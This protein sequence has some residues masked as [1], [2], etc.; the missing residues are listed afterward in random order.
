MYNTRTMRRFSPSMR[1]VA[2]GI[3]VTVIA[4]IIWFFNP[5]YLISRN[6]RCYDYFIQEHHLLEKSNVPVIVDIDE[7]SLEKYGQWPWPRYRLASMLNTIAESAPAAIGLDILFG[8]PDR[9]S[10][11]R[12]QSELQHELGFDVQFVGLPGYL[13]KHDQ[14]M[15]DALSNT[16]S[17]LGF[18]CRFDQPRPSEDDVLNSFE[19]GVGQYLK[20]RPFRILASWKQAGHRRD[21]ILAQGFVATGLITPIDILAQA[22]EGSGFM[23]AM[24]DFDGVLRRTPLLIEHETSLYPSLALALIQM[25][26]KESLMTLQMENRKIEVTFPADA[27]HGELNIPLDASANLFI[28]FRGAGKNYPY[29][30]A[31]DVLGKAVSPEEFKDKIVLVGS[32]AT[33]LKD[34]HVSPFGPDLVGVETHAAVIDTILTGDY[35]VIPS[36][37]HIIELAALLTIGLVIT[38]VFVRG[39]MSISLILPPVMWGAI[40]LGSEFCFSRWHMFFSPVLVLF[41]LT[42]QF[43]I[44]LLVTF[45]STEKE[46]ILLKNAFS[47][48]VSKSIVDRVI[49]S[50]R[51]LRLQGEEKEVSIL[52]ADIREFSALSERLSP[53]QL[54]QFLQDY[55]TPMTK[56]ITQNN[57]TLDKFIGD[58]IMAFWNAPVDIKDH[59]KWAFKAC[60][61]MLAALGELNEMFTEKYGVATNIGIG[62]HAG[63][64]RVGNMGTEELFNYTIIGDDVNVGARLESLSK[65]YGVQM[66]ISEVMKPHVPDTHWVQELDLVQVKGR[67]QPLRIYGLCSEKFLTRPKKHLDRYHEALDLYRDKKF[68]AAYEIFSEFRNDT[69][70][71]PLYRIYRER[72]L[73]FIENPPPQDWAGV[74]V[75]HRK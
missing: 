58:G 19:D 21:T 33:A 2:A 16:S 5:S 22:A 68:T 66:V 37:A 54:T 67:A 25:V 41:T 8:E 60:V 69:F 10:P 28:H 45:F 49:S 56:V 20:K 7:A 63:V 34:I 48:F 31:S 11:D 15:A 40:Y 38:L 6:N 44:L 1:L 59:K 47:K 32:S 73:F 71:R 13:M 27:T 74:F 72:C 30:S 9:T 18:Y 29:Y 70:Y 46:K 17:V 57:G 64:V 24:P 39:K 62:L 65:Y 3:I 43:F 12:I 26:R 35:I 75:H 42:I 50:G 14:M 52:F 4:A 55:F 53:E 51:D 61:D 23:N 36:W